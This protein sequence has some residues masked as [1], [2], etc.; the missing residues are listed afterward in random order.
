MQ[1][2]YLS[3][4]TY[5]DFYYSAVKFTPVEDVLK[6]LKMMQHELWKLLAKDIRNKDIIC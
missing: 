6:V 3:P 1:L 5:I 2:L 4:L